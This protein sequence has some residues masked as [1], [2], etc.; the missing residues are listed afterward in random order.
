[1]PLSPALVISESVVAAF[2]SL[3]LSARSATVAVDA[4]IAKIA[5][6]LIVP[7]MSH[8]PVYGTT[9]GVLHIRREMPDVLF[10]IIRP[11]A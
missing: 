3:S 11:S 1:M 6:D 7:V 8:R 4:T 9:S 10:Q 5:I 2:F